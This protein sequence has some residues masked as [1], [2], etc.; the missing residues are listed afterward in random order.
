MLADSSLH[1]DDAV[2]AGGLFGHDAHAE[3]VDVSLD[4]V[5]VEDHEQVADAYEDQAHDRRLA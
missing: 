2:A 1:S 3:V 4:R 5:G